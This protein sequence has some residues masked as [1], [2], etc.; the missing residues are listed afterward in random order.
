MSNLETIDDDPT[1]GGIPEDYHGTLKQEGW[2]SVE[3]RLPEEDGYYYVHNMRFGIEAHFCSF[4]DKKVWMS[5]RTKCGRYSMY[6][7]PHDCILNN[8]THWQPLP[9]PPEAS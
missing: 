4:E 9:P 5:P 3:D 1:D 2:V 8:I 6:E 7:S